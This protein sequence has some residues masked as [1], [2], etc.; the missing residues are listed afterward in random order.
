MNPAS[1]RS[2][3]V[4]PMPFAP[5][6]T[7]ASPCLTSNDNPSMTRRGPRSMVKSSAISCTVIGFHDVELS[8]G[9]AIWPSARLGFSFRYAYIKGTLYPSLAQKRGGRA[10]QSYVPRGVLDSVGTP[11]AQPF[12]LIFRRPD[13]ER[14][15]THFRRQ[16]QMQEN[17]HRRG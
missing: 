8:K 10:A 9:G 17:P 16:L 15:Y 7:R 14:P 6:S 5:V 4:L 3:V 11:A 2:N 13:L 12:V 1:V